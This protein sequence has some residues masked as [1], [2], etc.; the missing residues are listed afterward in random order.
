[1]EKMELTFLAFLDIK[2]AF[3][4]TNKCQLK[5]KVLKHVKLIKAILTSRKTTATVNGTNVTVITT[6]VYPRVGVLLTPLLW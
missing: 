2:E 1:M 4:N 6:K 3:D 5:E